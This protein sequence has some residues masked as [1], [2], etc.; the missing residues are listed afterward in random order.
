[1]VSTSPAYLAALEAGI[2]QNS[3]AIGAANAS[4]PSLSAQIAANLSNVGANTA[5][6]SANTSAIATNTS[7]ISANSIRITSNA[8]AN[9]NLVN[10]L[11]NL[12]FL[13]QDNLV[14]NLT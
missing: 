5:N 6:T 1:M 8:A 10:T 9:S 12:S 4:V 7:G 11:G 13:V 14:C 2:L 3:V